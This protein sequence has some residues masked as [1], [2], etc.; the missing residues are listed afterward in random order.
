MD[1]PSGV[2]RTTTIGPVL[3]NLNVRERMETASRRQDH[4]RF[5]WG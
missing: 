3:P 1:V 5:G 4:R 2:A